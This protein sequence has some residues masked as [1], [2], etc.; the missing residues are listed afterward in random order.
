MFDGILYGF[1]RVNCKHWVVPLVWPV[2]PDRAVVLTCS[3][4]QKRS[5]QAPGSWLVRFHPDKFDGPQHCA[6]TMSLLVSA[7]K[8]LLGNHAASV[9][10]EH[11]L[12]ISLN[13]S[14]VGNQRWLSWIASSGTWR[15]MH[16]DEIELKFEQKSDWIL[17]WHHV[18]MLV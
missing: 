5:R 18:L 8:E 6:Q 10:C 12:G 11:K 17:F 9:N 3:H 4:H 15:Q 13:L 7:G 14:L 1:R 16:T 2:W